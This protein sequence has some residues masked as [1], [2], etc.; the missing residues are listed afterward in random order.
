MWLERQRFRD[1]CC[2]FWGFLSI[3]FGDSSTQVAWC[4][5]RKLRESF[6]DPLVEDPTILR[7][8][9]AHLLLGVVSIPGTRQI[10]KLPKKSHVKAIC[11]ARK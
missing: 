2:L 10:L 3:Y 5:Q 6:L 1:G 4:Q 11:P 9:E 8:I 7:E